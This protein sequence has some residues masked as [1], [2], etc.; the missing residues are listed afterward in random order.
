MSDPVA[1]REALI[2]EAIGEVANLLDSIQRLTPEIQE[3]GREIGRANEGLV[4]SLAAFESQVIA[5]T[6]RTKVHTVKHILA[7][8]DEAARQ[9]IE[10]Q[11]R[12]M[13]DAA[14]VAFGAEIGGALHRMQS[15]SQRVVEPTGWRWDQ[16][17]THLA[18]AAIAAAATW[19]L[20]VS[21]WPR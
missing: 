4:N 17:L 9:S 7:R 11:A 16:W 18:A 3:V 13:A 1:A 14:R 20:A 5:L 8:T 12:A 21:L 19:V 6:E 15:T 2:I 10:S